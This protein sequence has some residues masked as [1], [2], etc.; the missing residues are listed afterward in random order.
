MNLKI[1]KFSLRSAGIAAAVLITAV[2]LPD[3]GTLWAG[4]DP[5]LGV[6]DIRPLLGMHPEAGNSLGLAYDPV[7][8]V[9]YLSHGSDPRG[10]FIYKLD[11]GGNLLSEFNFETA[12]R[13][14]SYPT[15][16]SYDA[17]SSHLFVLALGVGDGIGN[18][19]EM[20]PDGSTI[21]RELT[22]P[23]GGGIG[24]AVRDDGIWQSLFASDIIRHSTRNGVFIEDFSVASSFPGFPGPYNLTSSFTN[25]FFIIDHFGRRI[26][27]VD[28]HGNEVAVASTASLGDGRGLAIGS[29]VRAR[30]IFLQ[31]NNQEIYILS[32]EFIEPVVAVP[33]L[34]KT[35]FLVLCLL[36][37][38]PGVVSLRRRRLGLP[39]SRRPGHA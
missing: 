22:V 8:D 13:P 24:V 11:T 23:L 20:S 34:S 21:F 28:L 19:V 35:G 27:E 30:R 26:V 6:I 1:P 4:A 31:V 32:P 29:D 39:K 33:A 25:G 3:S 2:T 36:L 17:S 14:G 5:I 15:A 18:I 38:A 12:Y 10:G 9:L 7:S 16:L 37:A